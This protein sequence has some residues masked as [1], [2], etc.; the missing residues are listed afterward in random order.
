MQIQNFSGDFSQDEK[1]LIEHATDASIFKVRPKGVYFPKNVSDIIELVKGV[2]PGE[3][4]SVRAGGTCMTGGSLTEG[5]IMNL[6]KYMNKIEIDPSTQTATVETGA[7]FRDIEEAAKAHGLMFAPYPSSHLIAGIGG[8]IGNNASGEKSL[9]F[10]ATIDNVLALDVVLAHGEVV[11]T[12]PH[13]PTTEYEKSLVDLHHKYAD[14]LRHAMGQVKKVASG[15]RLDRIMQGENIDLTPLFVG[16]QGTLGIVTKAV[17]KLVPIPK[18]T[19]L[20]IIPINSIH[21]LPNILKQI[22][23]HNPESVETFDVHTFECAR[24]FMKPEAEKIE[25]FFTAETTALILAQFDTEVDIG[26]EKV[27]DTAVVEAAWKIRRSS[28]SL[29][30]DH[31]REGERA[32]PCVEDSIVP[33]ENF[34]RFVPGLVSIV[35]KFGLRYAFHGHIADGALR[36]IPIF[37]FK[38]PTVADKIIAFTR[39]VVALIKSLGGNL[40]ADHSDGIIRTPFLK[41][42]YGDEL[43]GVFEQIKKIFDPNGKFNPHKKVGGTEAD[44]KKYIV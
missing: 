30:R 26:G 44:I 35:E 32:V 27:T 17:L 33:V 2:G 39:E 21:D 34:D 22:L 12:G 37:D 9:R 28:Y 6:T 25:R 24:N 40:S 11:S 19:V 16:T 38:D 23:A 4:I 36:I 14:K 5:Y 8:M 43:Y 1:V 20:Y 41:E 31:H 3:S 18:N 29:V 15:Y 13:A 10:G 7:Y 42:F